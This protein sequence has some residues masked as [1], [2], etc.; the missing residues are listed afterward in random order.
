[1]NHIEEQTTIAHFTVET[2]VDFRAIHTS[3]QYQKQRLS[4]KMA[5]SATKDVVAHFQAADGYEITGPHVET[6]HTII[7]GQTYGCHDKAKGSESH[8]PRTKMAR[9][10]EI[11]LLAQ[12]RSAEDTPFSPS[13]LLQKSTESGYANTTMWTIYTSIAVWIIVIE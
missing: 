8:M 5:D 9:S 12:K 10:A 3:N 11:R 4:H 1:M 6:D 7:I 2:K 13:G